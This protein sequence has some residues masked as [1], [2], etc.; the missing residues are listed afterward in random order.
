MPTLFILQSLDQLGASSTESGAVPKSA[1]IGDFPNM[2][3]DSFF[4]LGDDDESV[5]TPPQQASPTKESAPTTLTNNGFESVD[6]TMQQP[7]GATSTPAGR[8]RRGSSSS[9]TT[10]AASLFPIYEAPAQV[11]SLP[12][13]LDSTA[14]SEWEGAGGGDGASSTA[15]LSAVT[16]EQLFQMLQK[17]RTRYHKYKGRYVEVA[18]AYTELEAE[19]AKIANVMQQTQVRIWDGFC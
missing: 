9:M 16:K 12:S 3:T 7:G 14:G 13:D 11:Y 4:S 1:T 8:T 2:N 18:K 6:L 17:M 5:M 10:E 19:K 15:Q